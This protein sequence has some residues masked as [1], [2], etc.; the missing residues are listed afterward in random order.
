MY[1]HIY[2][3]IYIHIKSRLIETHIYIYLKK[4]LAE[5][6]YNEQRF[7][8]PSESSALEMMQTSPT[9]LDTLRR[10]SLLIPTAG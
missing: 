5:D 7:M 2:I 6:G 1:T 3:Y 9:A 4:N 8:S 10:D